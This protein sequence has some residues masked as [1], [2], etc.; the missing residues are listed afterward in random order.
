MGIFCDRLK[1][2]STGALDYR[3]GQDKGRHCEEELLLLLVL[4]F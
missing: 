3:T 2:G 4:L 1:F